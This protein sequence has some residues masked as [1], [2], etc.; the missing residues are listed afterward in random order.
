MAHIIQYDKFIIKQDVCPQA[1]A[2]VVKM[3]AQNKT[4]KNYM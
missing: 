2:F 1:Q 3:L 4:E